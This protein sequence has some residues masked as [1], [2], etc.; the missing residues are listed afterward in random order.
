VFEGC[1][2]CMEV[3]F[4]VGVGEFEKMHVQCKWSICIKD[5]FVQAS[6]G[7]RTGENTFK[8]CLRTFVVTIKHFL[9][10]RVRF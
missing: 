1:A 6:F 3:D 7:T 9:C 5:C 2:L 4:D 8:P 10:V